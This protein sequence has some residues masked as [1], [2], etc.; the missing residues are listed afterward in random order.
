MRPQLHDRVGKWTHEPRSN[1]NHK[2]HLADAFTNSFIFSIILFR[3]FKNIFTFLCTQPKSKNTITASYLLY[4]IVIYFI[5]FVII[6]HFTYFY[7]LC[8]TTTRWSWGHKTR[9]FLCT[10]LEEEQA[11]LFGQFPES[12]VL[13]PEFPHG[14]NLLLLQHSALGVPTTWHLCLVSSPTK[15][16]SARSPYFALHHMHPDYSSLHVFGCIC[17]PNT[18]STMSHKLAPV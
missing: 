7:T 5:A 4:F 10:L 2:K 3:K 6:F 9:R 15:T 13:N 16:I 1:F 18:A 8:L 11:E 14:E 12:S 17:Y